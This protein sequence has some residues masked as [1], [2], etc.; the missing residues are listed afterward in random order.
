M[1]VIDKICELTKF[2]HSK[3]ILPN[4]LPPIRV[5]ENDYLIDFNYKKHNIK[6]LGFNVCC[7]PELLE[8]QLPLYALCVYHTNLLSLFLQ[9]E[10]IEHK[11]LNI[12]L[13]GWELSRYSLPFYGHTVLLY[14][15][16]YI[17]D[18][19]MLVYYKGTLEELKQGYGIMYRLGYVDLYQYSQLWRYIGIDMFQN[20]LE[21]KVDSICYTTKNE[22]L[23]IINMLKK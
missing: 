18:P 23:D 15:D 22:K 3:L 14:D 2:F 6:V 8:K 1:N 17:F 12:A 11:I 7:F 4:I 16:N 19:M 13:P 5:I 9:N 10:G 20:A 21:L